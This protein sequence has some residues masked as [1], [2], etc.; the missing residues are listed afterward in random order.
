MQN[1]AWYLFSK[2]QLM[3]PSPIPISWTPISTCCLEL[4]MLTNKIKT[5]ESQSSGIGSRIPCNACL[6]AGMMYTH[7]YIQEAAQYIHTYIHSRSS[8][9][10]L[11]LFLFLLL[12]KIPIAKSSYSS[13]LNMI[14]SISLQNLCECGSYSW[15]EFTKR[16]VLSIEGRQKKRDCIPLNFGFL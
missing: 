6:I 8:S 3:S 14:T 12:Y 5:W 9:I 15:L 4:Q 2:A 7:T 16:I 10:I 1:W 13:T 11:F